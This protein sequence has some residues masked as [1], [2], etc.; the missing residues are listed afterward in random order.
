MRGSCCHAK[1]DEI[2]RAKC[3]EYRKCQLGP[4]SCLFAGTLCIACHGPDANGVRVAEKL[5]APQLTKS[6]WFANGG[7]APV[8]ARV[9]FERPNALGSR[10]EFPRLRTSPEDWFFA[11]QLKST[12]ARGRSTS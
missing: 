10:A 9:L 3:S 1:G 12:Y 4:K 8:L 2:C 11:G 6:A 7:N 5:L